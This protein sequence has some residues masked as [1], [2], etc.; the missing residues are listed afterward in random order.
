MSSSSKHSLVLLLVLM[1]F[2]Y[3]G[4][5][6]R[7]AEREKHADSSFELESLKAERDMLAALVDYGQRHQDEICEAHSHE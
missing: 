2:L 5:K 6:G 7:E 4:L 1:A 3:G